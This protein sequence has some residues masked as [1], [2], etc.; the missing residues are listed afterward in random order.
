M[1]HTPDSLNHRVFVDRI[2]YA[3]ITMMS[4]LIIYDGWQTLKLIDVVGVIIGPVLA[5]FIA[6]VFSGAMAKHIEAGRIL[7]GR[8][9]AHVVAS[10][11]PF[12]LLCVPPLLIVAVLFAS[13][14]SLTD[15]IRATLWFGTATLGYWG[16]VAGRRAGFVRWR[17]VMVVVL[18]LLI[19][20]VILL[21]QVLLQ[22]GKAFS[23]GVALG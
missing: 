14:V 1:T 16:Y 22:P 17:L 9:W 5:M 8:E 11:A 2:I 21:L 4:V 18:G 12:L 23:G 6:H 20:V 3:T 13:G 7:T 10:E 15:S 19:G